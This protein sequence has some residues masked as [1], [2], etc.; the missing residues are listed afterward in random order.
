MAR[1]E[2]ICAA[3]WPSRDGHR[4]SYP[5]PWSALAPLA[6]PQ[7]RS[8][9][10]LERDRLVVD[11]ADQQHVAIE[12]LDLLVVAGEGVLGVLD[13]LPLRCQQLDELDFRAHATGVAH[14]CILS[15]KCGGSP[16]SSSVQG[17]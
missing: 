11:P 1:P 7:A 9:L 15:S 12:A 6:R 13:S 14:R 2:P 5:R 3:S 4:P 16:A 10:P 17:A 8:P